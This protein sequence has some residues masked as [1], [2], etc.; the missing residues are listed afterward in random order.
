[1]AILI[2]EKKLVN[3]NV[4]RY[5][6]RLNSSIARFI[7]KSP[8]FVTY[9]HVNYLE[10]TL[11]GGYRDIEEILGKRSP[12]KFQKIT[13][14]P[15][16]GIE[17]IVLNISD[18]DQG[19]DTDFQ[20]E[21]VILP[22]TIKPLQ[23]DFFMI[24]S[25]KG[26]FIFRV[27]AIQYDNIRPD[28]FYKIEYRFEYL[29]DQKIE[30]LNNQVEEKFTCILEN[31]G[32]E[33]TCLIQEEYQEVLSNIENLY[34]DMVNTY[35][36]IFYNERYNCFLGEIPGGRKLYDPLQTVFFNK[37]KLLHRKNDLKTIVL[38]EGFSDN[39]RKVKYEKSIY[40]LFERRDAKLAKALS[41]N[42]FPGMYKKDS[43]F[44][45]WHDQSVFIADIPILPNMEGEINLLPLGIANSFKMNAPTESKYIELMQRFIRNEKISL[46]D[47]PLDLNEELLT[48]DANE[49][50][51]FYTPILLYIIQTCMNEF[52]SNK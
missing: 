17:A 3:D 47:I 36:V 18:N 51:F 19:L 25:V 42:I 46:Y 12:L 20:G 39:K 7:D 34:N 43:C 40:R 24:N 27:T 33:N 2:D 44:Y 21:A 1:M 10:T 22:N 11:D 14:F 9:Y 48:L 16:Y 31:I 52:L 6:N 49:E 35:K 28:N 37:H 32:T 4:F 29:D 5:E 13:D 26:S 38:T 8:T 23:N 45:R 41:Y 50:V 15:L 30:D